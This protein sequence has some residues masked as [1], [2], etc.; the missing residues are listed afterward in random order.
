M[1]VGDQPLEEDRIYTLDLHVPQPIQGQTVVRVGVDCL[2][3]RD[4]DLAGK[5]WTGFSIIDVSHSGLES[6]HALVDIFGAA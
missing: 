1:I 6:I 4:A 5:Y 2:W 3:A